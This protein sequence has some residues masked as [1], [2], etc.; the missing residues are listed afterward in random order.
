LAEAYGVEPIQG[1]RV[2]S[3]IG[4]ARR[5]VE[6]DGRT[7]EIFPP[8]PA[9][10]TTSNKT[11]EPWDPL[12]EHLAY[13]L[14]HEG[15]HLEFLARLFQ[16]VSVEDLTGW[17]NDER[18]GQ[19]ARR[20]GFLYE[21]LTGREL[22]GVAAV[23]TGNYFDAI[24][25]DEY[26][27]AAQP[28]NNPRWR[29][30]DNLPGTREFC[31]LVRRTAGV[32]AAEQY[33]C[34]AR[35]DELNAEFGHDVLMRSA[36]WLT[37]KE[38]RASFAIEHEQDEKD[39]IRRF[40]AVM[41]RRIG[42]YPQLLS[43]QTLAELQ[44]EIVSTRSTI[45]QFGLRLSPVFVGETHR[46]E[47]VVHYVAPH[48][49]ALPGLLQ[50]LEGFLDKT[51]GKP[52]IVRASTAAFGFIYIHPLADGNGRVHRFIINDVLRRDGAVPK[53][54]ILP[55]SAAITERAQNIA[56]YDE[57]L[58]GFSKPLMDRVGG[59]FELTQSRQRY[60]DG[61]E[62]NM[63]FVG[64]EEAMPAWRYPDLT[65]HAEY[66][67]QIIDQTIRQEMRAEASVLREWTEARRMVKD[68]IDGPDADIDRI[69]RS[70]RDN[71]GAVS[72]KLRKEFPILA[73][74]DVVEDLVRALGN[75]F[76]D[77]V[78]EASNDHDGK[79]DRVAPG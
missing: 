41:E 71:K 69:I 11:P 62:S 61:I 77:F 59:L 13:A 65:A 39:R 57:I 49:E 55:V 18:T 54:F 28:V 58:E 38:S 75:A 27:A 24:D 17:M 34:I 3:G 9:P 48:W 29:I 19:Y 1:F 46:F 45:K 64:Y 40:A 78:P 2:T 36:V 12:K 79:D 42:E 74:D 10:K 26:F 14:K 30:R 63:Q 8:P 35:L 68:V 43:A 21:W 23:T 4:T 73:G 67:G 53:P 6:V 37:I 32:M 7:R 31:P 76:K 20:A 44:Q 22:A 16:A 56:R 60:E 50:G 52:S 33:D 25:S 15:V 72:N 47:Q 66:L 5:T 51:V 70:V